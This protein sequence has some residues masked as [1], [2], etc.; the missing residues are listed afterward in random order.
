MSDF[1]CNPAKLPSVCSI[2]QAR[3]LEWVVI[4]F[5]K[6]SSQPRNR[7][8]ISCIADDSLPHTTWEAYIYK[9]HLFFF[10]NDDFFTSFFYLLAAL[11]AACGVLVLGPGIKHTPLP[12]L[13]A[14]SLNHWTTREVPILKKNYQSK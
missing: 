10:F 14:W 11:C 4:S 1:F 2:P 7:T 6:R 9:T 5:S 3:I 12:A 8:L 13:G